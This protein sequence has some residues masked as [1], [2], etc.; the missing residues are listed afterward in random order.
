MS[1]KQQRLFGKHSPHELYPEYYLLKVKQFNDV[2]WDSLDEWIYF[3]KNR[4][5]KGEF[6]ARGLSKAKE[7]LDILNLSDE[8]RRAYELHMENLSYQA[9]LYNSS[10]VEG[11]E[12]G[13]EENRMEMAKAMRQ[14]GI[15]PTT[16]AKISGLSIAATEKL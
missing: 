11:K 2:A 5:I 14:E 6:W 8:E 1:E 15:N 7:V 12:D 4:E 9:S 10:Y 3:L 13:R 16:I